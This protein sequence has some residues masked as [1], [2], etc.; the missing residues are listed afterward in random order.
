MMK[1]NSKFF[2]FEGGVKKALLEF[3]SGQDNF[4]Y[5]CRAIEITTQESVMCSKISLNMVIVLNINT[6]SR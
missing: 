2:F 1:E 6:K 3:P 5:I 4:N